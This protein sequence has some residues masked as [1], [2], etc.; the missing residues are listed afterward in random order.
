MPSVLGDLPDEKNHPGSEQQ[1]E[2]PHELLV[3]ED[4]AE[5]ADRPVE[6]R[7]RA[8][9]AQVEVG[10]GAELE[11]HGVH[12]QNTE[13]RNPSYQVEAGYARGL[14]DGAGVRALSLRCQ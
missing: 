6:P 7:L 2:Q 14:A 9:G 1:R 4:L 11:R 3:D 5:D 12:Q 8:A 13:H 10:S